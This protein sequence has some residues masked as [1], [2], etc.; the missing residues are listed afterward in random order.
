[1]VWHELFPTPMHG[2]RK[3]GKNL[4]ISTKRLFSQFRVLTTKFH[5]FWPLEKLLEKSISGPS[6]KIPSDAHAH[7]HVKLHR[8]VKNCVVLHHL[9][10]LFNN[11]NAVSNS[12]PGDKLC[13]VYSAKQLQ[14]PAESTAKLEIISTK[15]CQNSATCFSLNDL[16]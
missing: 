9:A 13:T 10:T 12:L 16:L 11:T 8:F 2:C 1:M 14:N 3:R 6:G 15:Y 7:K 5:C 4:K